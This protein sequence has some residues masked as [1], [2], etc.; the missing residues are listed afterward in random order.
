M[1]ITLGIPLSNTAEISL[2]FSASEVKGQGHFYVCTY[3]QKA[4]EKIMPT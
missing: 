1:I 3:F 2:T 4:G